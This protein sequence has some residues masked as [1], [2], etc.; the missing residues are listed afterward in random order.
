MSN[1]I[2]ILLVAGGLL[3]LVLAYMFLQKMPWTMAFWSWDTQ[4]QLSF[5]FMASMQAAIAVAMIWIGLSGELA[6]LA[7]GALNL[8]VMMS[9]LAV[10]LFVWVAPPTGYLTELAIFCVLFALFNLLLFL[11]ARHIPV[12]DQR[13]TPPL[14]QYSYILF[15]TA[16]VV[17]GVGLILEWPNV[18]SWNLPPTTS[19]IFGWMFIGDAFYFGYALYRGQWGLASAP[20]LSFLA[21]DLVLIRPFILRLLNE[22]LVLMR[23]ISLSIY[24]LVLIYSG[25]LAIYFLFIHKNTGLWRTTAGA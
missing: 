23:Q 20:L 7:A 25:L 13:P 14:V 6:A 12:R 18:F 11:W 2:R 19:K 15:I 10:T 5:T 22:D 17:V 4:G 3:N 16:L 1:I 21:Y 8:V 9:G 24:I